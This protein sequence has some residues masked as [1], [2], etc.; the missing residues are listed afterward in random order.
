MGFSM[1]WYIIIWWHCWVIKA[2][3]WKKSTNVGFFT[4]E[5]RTC[6]F[7]LHRKCVIR[8]NSNIWETRHDEREKWTYTFSVTQHKRL[9]FTWFYSCMFHLIL[10]FTENLS[11]QRK[12][13]DISHNLAWNKRMGENKNSMSLLSCPW[14]SRP[15]SVVFTCRFCH[16]TAFLYCDFFLLK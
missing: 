8:K 4:W 10:S 2:T 14:K 3:L 7:F 5:K 11:T 15:V 16:A 1:S 13:S 9:I 12:L 6:S